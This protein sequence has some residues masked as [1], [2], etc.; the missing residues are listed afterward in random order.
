M[1][2]RKTWIGIFAGI[3]AVL[4]FAIYWS[5]NQAQL[6]S[7]SEQD[8]KLLTN[9]EDCLFNARNAGTT[10]LAKTELAK[11]IALLQQSNYSA[12]SFEF[13]DLNANLIYLQ[14]QPDNTVLPLGIKNAIEKDS[15]TIISSIA[16]NDFSPRVVLWSSIVGVLIFAEIVSLVAAGK[17]IFECVQEE[18]SFTDLEDS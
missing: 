16:A 5:W 6:V 13:R 3:C 18:G 10:D 8:E 9:S 11:G 12:T 14:A 4:G 17:L 2:A 15:N 7:P 1:T